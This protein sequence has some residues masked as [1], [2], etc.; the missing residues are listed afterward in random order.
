MIMHFLLHARDDI[1]TKRS[2][3]HLLDNFPFPTCGASFS[4]SILHHTNDLFGSTS[5][6]NLSMSSTKPPFDLQ[7]PCNPF[8]L[9][10]W[11]KQQETVKLPSFCKDCQWAAFIAILPSVMRETYGL[12]AQMKSVK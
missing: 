3:I 11:G 12:C 10:R 4:C 8:I 7:P 9:S 1:A 2:C 6:D 5:L